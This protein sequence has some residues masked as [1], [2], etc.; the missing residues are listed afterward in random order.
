[1]IETGTRAVPMLIGG[2]FVESAARETLDVLLREYGYRRLRWEFAHTPTF[3]YY[4]SVVYLPRLIVAAVA[5][6]RRR[7]RP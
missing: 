5:A 6:K 3:I 1:M 4:P 7:R 2:E